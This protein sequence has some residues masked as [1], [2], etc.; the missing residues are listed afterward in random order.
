MLSGYTERACCQKRESSSDSEDG[1]SSSDSD[2]PKVKR[3]AI[4][5]KKIKMRVKKDEADKVLERTRK[6]MLRFMNSQC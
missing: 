5:G 2:D 4:T 6:E 1:S 3:S